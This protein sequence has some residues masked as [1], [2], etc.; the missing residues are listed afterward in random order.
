M[1]IDFLAPF[2]EDMSLGAGSDVT[3]L[4]QTGTDFDF[5]QSRDELIQR[6]VR[7][8]CTNPGEWLPF[9]RY[10]AGVRRYVNEPLSSAIAFRIKADCLAQIVEEPDVATLPAPQVLLKR[11]PDGLIVVIQ[12]YTQSLQPVSFSFNPNSPDV[13]TGINSIFS[14]VTPL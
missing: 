3:I 8:L 14:G 11:I 13:F 5:I 1:A 6:I 4:G 7:R 10:G 12:L 9:P 2:G